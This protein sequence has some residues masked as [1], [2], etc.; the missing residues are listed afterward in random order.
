MFWTEEETRLLSFLWGSVAT[1]TISRRLGRTVTAVVDKAYRMGLGRPSR[2]T[3]S[4]NRLCRETGYHPQQIRYAI[5]NLGLMLQHTPD[6]RL[7][8]AKPR[9]YRHHAITFEQ[10]EAILDYLKQHPD[11][12]RVYCTTP[13]HRTKQGV[14]GVGNKPAACLRCQRTDRPHRG[15]G[16]CGTCLRA[17]QRHKAK[18]S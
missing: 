7:P 9:Q 6:T 1:R 10:E 17:D 18:G 13:G 8:S 15:K 4:L 11:G 2:G 5:T 12:E 3:K 14:W 16:F